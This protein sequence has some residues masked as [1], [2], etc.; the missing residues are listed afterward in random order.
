[1]SAAGLPRVAWYVL[2]GPPRRYYRIT[3]LVARCW[4]VA[5][6]V[7]R[8]ARFVDSIVQ[9]ARPQETSP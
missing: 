7:D 5:H 9:R 1:M 3:S 2:L 6:D 8:H 4:V